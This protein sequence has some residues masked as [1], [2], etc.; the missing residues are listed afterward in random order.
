M[1]TTN[2]YGLSDVQAQALEPTGDVALVAGAG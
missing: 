2:P 1:T